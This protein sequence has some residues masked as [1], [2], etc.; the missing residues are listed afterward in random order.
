MNVYPKPNADFSWNPSSPNTLSES[1]VVFTPAPQ[2]MNISDYLWDFH[3][4][5][6][7][8][9][10]SPTHQFDKQ[11]NYAITLVLNTEHGCKDTIT[12]IVEVRDEFLLFVPNAFTPNGDGNNDTFKPKGIGMKN[13][14]MSIFD[15]WGSLIY[16][17]NEKDKGWDGTF[18]GVF[19]Q[20][21]VYVYNITIIDNKSMRHVRTGHVTLMK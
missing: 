16:Q 13:Y 4:I 12:K 5:S 14:D 17:G 3:G 20:D 1:Y 8:T 6:Q 21:D 7:S 19:C 2:S 9:D 18:K 11:D 15:R 10:K